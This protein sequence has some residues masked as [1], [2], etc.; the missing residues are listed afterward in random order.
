M[1]PPPSDSNDPKT[2]PARPDLRQSICHTLLAAAFIL[3]GILNPFSNKGVEA[4]F[5]AW[6]MLALIVVVVFS[7]YF[8]VRSWLRWRTVPQKIQAIQIQ[9]VNRKRGRA[10]SHAL[11][12]SLSILLASFAFLGRAA[13]PEGEATLIDEA[14]F[15]TGAVIVI[16][17]TAV[18]AQALR[19]LIAIN[20]TKTSN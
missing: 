17:G 10:R 4:S 7:W 8:L 1:S 5:H 6:M 19:N 14:L 3:V 18:L 16:A 2:L 15:Y 9:K 13:I 20:K 11:M 12:S